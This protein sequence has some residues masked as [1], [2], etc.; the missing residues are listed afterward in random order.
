MSSHA[1]AM[2]ILTEPGS[3]S[4]FRALFPLA[5]SG[6]GIP[7]EPEEFTQEWTASGKVLLVDD[8]PLILSVG[9]AMLEAMGFSVITGKDGSDGLNRFMGSSG[10]ISLVI[11]DLTMPNMDGDEVFR[12]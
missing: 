12:R 5:P 11:L 8:E 2:K 6:G 9:K 4:S 10:G 1:G 7:I 3:G